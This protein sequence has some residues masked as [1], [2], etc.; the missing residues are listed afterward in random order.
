[1]V[2]G[3]VH[4]SVEISC[5]CRAEVLEWHA[6]A[7]NEAVAEQKVA[8]L[9]AAI[10]AAQGSELGPGHAIVEQA[11]QKLEQLVKEKK[12]QRHQEVLHSLLA[13]RCSA[14]DRANR[15]SEYI[16]LP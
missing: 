4:P 13:G 7:I 2:P 16:V 1:M 12:K 10:K 15:L 9:R 14:V 8:P 6:N 5:T 11:K 3:S